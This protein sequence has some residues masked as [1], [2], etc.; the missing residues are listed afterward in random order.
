MDRVL[1]DVS[2][3]NTYLKMLLPSAVYMTLYVVTWMCL[4]RMQPDRVTVI[5]MTIDDYIPFVEVFIIPYM[6]WFAYA[7][8]TVLFF[9]LTMRK[10]EYY[11]LITFLYVGM[12][13]FLVVS[14]VSPNVHY[15]RPAQFA[16]DNVFTAIIAGLYRADTPTNL[17]PSIHVY[18]AIGAHCAIMHSDFFKTRPVLRRMSFVTCVLIILSTM[19]I[20][21]HS[22]FDV[23]TAFAMSIIM[24]L[25]VY[26]LG[27]VAYEK[28]KLKDRS[29]QGL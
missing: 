9:F 24:Y 23:L 13:V 2:R 25:L 21:Q 4:E 26:Q 16:R 20:K 11:R 5:H 1:H 12:T 17:W 29:L 10:D 28:R 15:L 7:V 14:F 22:V 19:F 27:E 3:R 8:G 18:N 6:A